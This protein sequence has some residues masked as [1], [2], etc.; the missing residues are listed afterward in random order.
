MHRAKYLRLV[1]EFVVI[2]D[3]LKRASFF[4]KLEE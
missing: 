1:I 2:E 4:L 3:H